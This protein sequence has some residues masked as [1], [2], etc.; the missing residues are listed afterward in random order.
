MI[1]K[2][3]TNIHCICL[4]NLTKQLLVCFHTNSIDAVPFGNAYFGAGAGPIHLDGVDCRGSENRLI[5]CSR[6]P[7]VNCTNNHSEDAG[8]RCQGLWYIEYCMLPLV[9]CWRG[10]FLQIPKCLNGLE[11][12]TSAVNKYMFNRMKPKKTICFSTWFV[13]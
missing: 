7:S 10:A 5:D 8:V 11:H 4:H 6:S 9:M 2:V 3:I 1:K 12:L 13:T